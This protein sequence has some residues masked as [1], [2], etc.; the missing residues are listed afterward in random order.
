MTHRENLWQNLTRDEIAEARDAGAVVAIPIGAIEQ[1][2]SHLPVDTD[3]R[4][5]HGG[6]KARREPRQDK[7]AG[8][9]ESALRFLAAPFESCRHRQPQA[10]NLSRGARR[11]GVFVCPNR[12]PAHRVRQWSWR[13]FRAASLKDRG[14]S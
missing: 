12:L 11:H 4:L 6:D 5:V 3:A 2:G 10:F 9:A 7:S 14:S 8:R 1:H 13:K